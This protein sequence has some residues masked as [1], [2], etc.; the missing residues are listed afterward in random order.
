MK[1]QYGIPWGWE[2]WGIALFFTILATAALAGLTMFICYAFS[3][4]PW[5]PERIK[6]EKIERI[7]ALRIIQAAID[8]AIN[9]GIRAEVERGSK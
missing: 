9:E 7:A 2:D 8:S 3:F 1:N 6:A 5:S 4:G